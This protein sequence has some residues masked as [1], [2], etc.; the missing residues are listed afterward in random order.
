MLWRSI[1]GSLGFSRFGIVKLL[2]GETLILTLSR[3]VFGILTTFLI[4]FI[5]RETTPT[6]QILITPG[7]VFGAVF[8]AIIGAAAG[9]V[10]PA[11]RAASFDPVV[12]L[13]YE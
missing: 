6:L 9:A 13:A 7:W 11:L 3:S 10:Y 5:L 8:L 1:R 4:Q 12:A 2:L